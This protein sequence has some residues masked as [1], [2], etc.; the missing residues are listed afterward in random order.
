MG[1]RQGNSLGGG[2][3][4]SGPPRL[5]GLTP[6]CQKPY[7]FLCWPQWC[8][9]GG[10][11]RGVAFAVSRPGGCGQ[12]QQGA[13]K[14]APCTP[15]ADTAPAKRR[16]AHHKK[17]II[18]FLYSKWFGRL[19]ISRRL[20]R[21]RRSA[22]LSGVAKAGAARTSAARGGGPAQVYLAARANS[23]LYRGVRARACS[24]CALAPLTLTLRRC[25]A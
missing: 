8:H 19:K 20:R 18:R 2:R 17:H 3:R 23:C 16:V 11:R 6:L 21:Q 12:W 10:G 7:L 22:A 4:G 14:G 13:G 1:V 9:S 5:A 24:R 15:G 25:A